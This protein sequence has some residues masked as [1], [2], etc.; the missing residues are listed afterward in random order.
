V[1]PTFAL[2]LGL[3]VGGA[4]F[5]AT[6]GAHEVEILLMGLGL[7]LAAAWWTLRRQGKACYVDRRT[8]PFF[9]RVIGAFVAAYLALLTIAHVLTRL[10]P[11]GFTGR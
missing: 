2:V 10:L 7:T 5:L 9:L 1:P 8:L 4:T 6:L 3:G 11:G